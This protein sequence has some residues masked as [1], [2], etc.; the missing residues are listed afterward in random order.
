MKRSS[1]LAGALIGLAT[2][3]VMMAVSYLGSV[4]IGLPFLPF[5]LFD[6]LTRVLPGG[7]I[8]PILG[9]MISIISA[10]HLGPT[11]TTAKLAE[12]IQALGL[13]ALTG[14]A[15]GLVLAWVGVE[16]RA[17][18]ERAGLVGGA[19]LWVGMVVVEVS[20]PA[21]SSGLFLSL[22]WLLI[23]LAGWG[24]QLSRL[25]E[26]F[27][28]NIRQPATD[29]ASSTDSGLTAF[30]RQ[31]TR[32]NML[33]LAGTSAVSVVVLLLGL[34][35]YRQAGTVT[36]GGSA[37]LPSVG[38]ATSTP[39]HIPYGPEYTSG[40]AASPSPAVL[41]ER[42]NPAP[43]TQAEI[44]PADQFYRVDINALPPVVDGNSWRLNLT[45]LVKNPISLTLD[46]VWA[47]PSITQAVT[48]SCVSNLVGGDL[49]SS[50]Y[51][52]GVRFKDILT[53]AGVQ[54]GAQEIALTAADGYYEGL[55]LDEAMDERTLLVYAMNGDPLTTEHGFPL[56]LYVPGH[57]GMKLPKWITQMEVIDHPAAGYWVDRGWSPTA[58]PQT[59]S[60][61]DTVAVDKS[62]LQKTG[63][64]PLGGIAWSGER[65]ISKVE[66]QV[67]NQPWVTADLRSPAISP[68]T[69][70]QWRYD[71]KP[72]PGSHTVQ[73]RATDGAGALQDP[74]SSD[75]APEGAT[76]IDAVSINI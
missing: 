25:L 48:L 72:A 16:R 29:K 49:I 52:T 39:H 8:A 22:T 65:G 50:N 56:R 53:E 34:E 11:D 70:V 42:I 54:P 38:G 6:W 73:V 9:A 74:T 4:L 51:W 2:S 19:I 69:W 62:D 35:K 14:L 57:Y 17:W 58:I 44:T 24:W 43:G 10:L 31:M 32:R 41:A 30:E 23:L 45:G 15:F 76:G 20:L 64:M 71:W 5:D 61:I 1:L 7:L 68:L 18:L 40:P 46:E 66:V 12:Q 55:S 47:R 27:T 60:V 75:P 36:S 37:A 63:I 28:R 33:V 26:L 59:T 3:L 21:T 13:V 67:D